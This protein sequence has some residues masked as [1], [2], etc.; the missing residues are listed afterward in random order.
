MGLLVRFDPQELSVGK[1]YFCFASIL[2]FAISFE[3]GSKK[4]QC[5]VLFEYVPQNEDELELKLGD[6]IDINEEVSCFTELIISLWPKVKLFFWLI[7]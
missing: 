1:N 2:S 5:K 4:R 7:T 3:L 6:V